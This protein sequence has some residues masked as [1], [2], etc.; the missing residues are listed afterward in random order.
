MNRIA[1]SGLI[2]MD[3]KL[4][5]P[6]DRVNEFCAR[7]VMKRVIVTFEAVEQGSTEAQLGYYNK[8]ILPTVQ[9]ALKETG[10]LKT[11]KQTDE[12]LRQQCAACYSGP[13]LLEVRQLDKK[14]MSEFIDWIKQFAAENLYVYI[15]DSNFI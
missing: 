8:Y 7:N 14:Q 3:G 1:E 15:E 9:S 12:W 11:E 6:M 5:L 4:R 13:D 10:E 2:G